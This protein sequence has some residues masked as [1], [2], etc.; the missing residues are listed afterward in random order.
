MIRLLSDVGN[1]RVKSFLRL[2]STLSHPTDRLLRKVI[3]YKGDITELDVDVIVNAAN[4]SLLGGGG[5]DGAIHRKAGP[6][7]RAFNQTLG[8]CKTSKLFSSL[9]QD[10]YII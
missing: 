7:L 10:P 9:Y 6:Q 1:S 4:H 2:F 8:G 5:V 3:V